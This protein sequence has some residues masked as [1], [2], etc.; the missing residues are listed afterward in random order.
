MRTGDSLT[1]GKGERLNSKG[2]GVEGAS[3]APC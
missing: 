3:D 1:S 2:E